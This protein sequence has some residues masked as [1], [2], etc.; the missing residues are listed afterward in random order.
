MMG[1]KGCEV[2]LLFMAQH[3]IYLSNDSMVFQYIFTV[4]LVFHYMLCL[5]VAVNLF[6]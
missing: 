2:A 4:L 5:T 6:F 1:N 3:K